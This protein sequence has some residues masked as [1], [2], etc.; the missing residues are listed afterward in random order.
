[1]VS[2]MIK[3][4]KKK[5]E[6]INIIW[7]KKNKKIGKIDI[8]IYNDHLAYLENFFVYAENRNLGI[9]KK[10]LKKAINI[11]EE[12]KVGKMSCT[13]KSSNIPCLKIFI[14]NGFKK[15]GILR[16]HFQKKSTI[17][18]LSKFLRPGDGIE[19]IYND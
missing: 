19:N 9:G 11:C 15:E 16:D 13:I 14:K 10:L 4:K 8:T 18:I 1:M 6:N 3:I 7:N 5:I 2:K 17:I 12:K